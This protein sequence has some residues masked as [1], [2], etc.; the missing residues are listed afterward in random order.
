V[1]YSRLAT[2]LEGTTGRWVP[3]TEPDASL[4]SIRKRLAELVDLRR[5]FGLT[6]VQRDEYL[7]LVALEAQQLAER[8]RHG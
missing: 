6:E 1:V 2:L 3:V 7:D 4:E 8:D 5:E